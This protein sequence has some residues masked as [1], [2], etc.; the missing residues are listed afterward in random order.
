VSHVGTPPIQAAIVKTVARPGR[1]RGA[2]RSELRLPRAC[3]PLGIHPSWSFGGGP[4]SRLGVLF[5]ACVAGVGAALA[6]LVPSRTH[7]HIRLRPV[8]WTY[9]GLCRRLPLVRRLVRHW[10]P[11]T[12]TV[13]GALRCRRVVAP[14]AEGRTPGRFVPILWQWTWGGGGPDT[15]MRMLANHVARQE[16]QTRHRNSVQPPNKKYIAARASPTVVA[17]PATRVVPPTQTQSP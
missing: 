5:L 14:G 7:R 15:C 16:E 11:P 12:L 13:D 2:R 9:D 1:Q 3:A 4:S 8:G 6:P 17:Y 10:A